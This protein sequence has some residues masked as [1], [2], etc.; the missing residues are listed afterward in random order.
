MYK[1]IDGRETRLLAE[2]R[3]RLSTR[4]IG[5]KLQKRT[6]AAIFR[7]YFFLLLLL[8]PLLLLSE[9]EKRTTAIKGIEV[10]CVNEDERLFSLPSPLLPPAHLPDGLRMMMSKRKL[11]RIKQLILTIEQAETNSTAAQ[12]TESRSSGI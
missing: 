10:R 8:S 5:F 9:N 3:F 12:R 2:T 4:S 6:N 7:R 11:H 1:R